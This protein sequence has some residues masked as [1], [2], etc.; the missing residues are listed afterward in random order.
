MTWVGMALPESLC[1]YT[2]RSVGDP[3]REIRSRAIIVSSPGQTSVQ[4]VELDDGV[5]NG[6]IDWFGIASQDHDR[7]RSYQ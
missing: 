6:L 5:C 7:G 4:D 1:G 3:R 2:N